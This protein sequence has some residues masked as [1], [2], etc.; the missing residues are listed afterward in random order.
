MLRCHLKPWVI[1][2]EGDKD[3]IENLKQALS[4]SIKDYSLGGEMRWKRLYF[5]LPNGIL[6]RRGLENWLKE[7]FEVEVISDSREE[8]EFDYNFESFGDINLRDYQEDAVIR[9][10]K[11]RRGI[12]LAPT[13]SGKT[14]IGVGIINACRKYKVVYIVHRQVLLEQVKLVLEQSLNEEVGVIGA[15]KLELDKNI[16][17]AMIQTLYSQ[18]DNKDLKAW[19]KE[20]KVCIV[21]EAHRYSTKQAINALSIFD[22]VQIVIGLT[23]TLPDSELGMMRLRGIFGDVIY[24]VGSDILVDYDFIVLPRVIFVEGD[25]EVGIRGRLKKE[26]NWRKAGSV[27]K[28]WEIIREGC[29]IENEKRNA[30]IA[31]VVIQYL[32]KGVSGILI[33]VDLV[34]QGEILSQMLG[35][36]LV[37]SGDREY[38]EKFKTG[39]IRALISS[40]ILDE[41][42]DVT[43]INVVVLASGGKSKI[44]LLQRIGRGMRKAKGKR[45]FDVVDFWD[46]ETPL[47]LK[48][49]KQRLKIYQAQGWEVEKV[50]YDKE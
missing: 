22:S 39:E 18:K 24:E 9:A 49:S 34:R 37:W 26:V 33:I 11:Y 50:N 12:I 47:L 35:V 38:Y 19:A 14:F 5:S 42:I 8:M 10:L 23:G 3:D 29:I 44:R 1:K 21:D 15:G 36:P 27:R 7:N 4:F 30:V 6:V 40:P 41:G 43:G 48:H 31:D 46:A 17:V 13:G 32:R 2:V 45:S 20:V 25:W 16:T 28:A